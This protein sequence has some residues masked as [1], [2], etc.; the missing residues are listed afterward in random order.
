MSSPTVKLADNK[1]NLITS[2]LI[3]SKR[4]VDCG[5]ILVKPDGTPLSTRTFEGVTSIFVTPAPADIEL[6]HLDSEDID[7]ETSFMLVDLSDTTN[8]P[9]TNTGHIDI[10]YIL[11]TVAP[12]AT[13]AGDIQLGFLTNVDAENGDFN[14]IYE[15]HLDKKTGP[16]ISNAVFPFAAA[17]METDHYFGP[18]KANSTLFQTDVNLQGPSGDTSFP[19]GN[20]DLVMIVGRTAGEASVGITVGYLAQP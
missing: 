3:G 19:S 4:A 9:H 11:I 20:G 8:W 15:I 2:T 16:I 13:Y 7:A 6:I 14:G 10:L 5:S 18:I 1:G 12:D 17:S